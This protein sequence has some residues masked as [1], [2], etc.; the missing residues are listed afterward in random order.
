MKAR[1]KKWITLLLVLSL[2]GTLPFLVRANKPV[3]LNETITRQLKGGSEILP[4]KKAVVYVSF[5]V[6]ADG[7]VYIWEMNG[8]Q[9]EYMNFVKNRLE[10]LH[11]FNMGFLP[12]KVYCYKINFDIR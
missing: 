3:T 10:K 8:N 1:I 6:N 12:G 9:E 2:T 4:E 11:A 5:S 7:K